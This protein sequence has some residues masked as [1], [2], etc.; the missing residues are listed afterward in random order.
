MNAPSLRTLLWPALL[1][2]ATFLVFL[3]AREGAFLIDDV[4]QIQ[5]NPAVK[6]FRVGELL[7]RGYWENVTEIQGIDGA[8]MAVY[9]PLTSLSLSLS[10]QLFGESANPYRIENILLHVVATLLVFALFKRFCSN[11]SAAFCGALLFGVAPIHVEAVCGI[12]LRAEILAA[13]FGCA[14]LLM[15]ERGRERIAGAFL[16]CA[17]LSKESAI[18]LPILAVFV[19]RVRFQG[20]ARTQTVSL[21]RFLPLGLAVLL[22]LGIRLVVLGRLTVAGETNTYFGGENKLDVW[23]TMARFFVEH[24][25]APALLGHPIIFDYSRT[26]IEMSH[27]GDVLAWISLVL[28]LALGILSLVLTW[29]W[30]SPLWLG[31]LTF[32]LLI[33]P[34]SNIL[35]HIG[36]IGANRLAYLPFLGVSWLLCLCVARGLSRARPILKSLTLACTVAYLGYFS[37]RTYECT[38]AWRDA[39][40]LY[41]DI[42]ERAPRNNLARTSLA[43]ALWRDILEGHVSSGEERAYASE[44]FD[45]LRSALGENR[46]DWW[47]FY[48]VASEAA[49]VAGR[50]QDLFFLLAG[51]LTNM[52]GATG[53]AEIDEE[54]IRTGSWQ[55]CGQRMQ[56]HA[57]RFQTMRPSVTRGGPH[58]L[59]RE[60]ACVLLMVLAH[61]VTVERGL[62][63]AEAGVAS[64]PA[65]TEAFRKLQ[66]LW[67]RDVL[68]NGTPG[69][70]KHA[71]FVVDRLG[72]KLN[73]ELIPRF[74]AL[75]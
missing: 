66:T 49:I 2:A 42:L 11:R 5:R 26:T 15:L 24:Y 71:R 22:Y 35:T 67:Q 6:E 58:A 54:A 14:M 46:R 59:E 45:H 47:R 44:V 1:F 40:S 73:Q 70:A 56:A 37:L 23:L 4:A 20:P 19:A 55:E 52:S 75:R 72:T 8:E 9:R 13:I 60:L 12:V 50:E 62:T 33:G 29:R 27:T 64:K 57:S 3:P 38:H 65:V 28:M 43:G 74:Q 21:Q 30:Q 51:T 36:V 69:F 68:G 25:I 48:R 34:T 10:Y 61:Y 41:A 16:L 17:L 32:L 31:P 53:L 39:K 7:G 18:A 63:S